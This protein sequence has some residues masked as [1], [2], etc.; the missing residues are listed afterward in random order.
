MELAVQLGQKSSDLQTSA[1]GQICHNVACHPCC[2]GHTHSLV[3]IVVWVLAKD[4]NLDIIEGTCVE[5]PAYSMTLSVCFW[6][7]DSRTW[8]HQDIGTVP[9][10]V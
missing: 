3:N 6:I 2:V 8:V 7:A 9:E 10:Y 1:E 5:C 4:H